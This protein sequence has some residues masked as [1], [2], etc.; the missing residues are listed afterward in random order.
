MSSGTRVYVPRTRS[1][2]YA[3]L[4]GLF[5]KSA[6]SAE[7]AVTKEQL[8]KVAQ[9]YC[10]K[11]F[12]TKWK[13]SRSGEFGPQSAWS[14]MSDLVKKRKLV[15]ESWQSNPRKKIF[16]LS[17][18]GL[19]VASKLYRTSSANHQAPKNVQ[20]TSS[21]T[22]PTS[23]TSIQIV[24]E[25]GVSPSS[26]SS[27]PLRN[28]LSESSPSSGED[29]LENCTLPE[30]RNSHDNETCVSLSASQIAREY[31]LVLIADR[32]EN[33]PGKGPPIS[34]KIRLQGVDCFMTTLSLGDFAWGLKKK[35]SQVSSAP[36]Y[37]VQSIIERKTIQDLYCSV[38][39]G[40]YKEQG[41]RLRKTELQV[42]YILE[43]NGRTGTTMDP[44][45]RDGVENDLWLRG[46][47]VHTTED[48]PSTV[49]Y[50]VALRQGIE[51]LIKSKGVSKAW[52]FE[53]FQRI[54]QHT[55]KTATVGTTWARM[56]LQIPGV[57]ARKAK[58]IANEYPTLSLLVRKY[59][60]LGEDEETK[61]LLLQNLRSD[62]SALR[63]GPRI[64]SL[65]YTA[66]TSETYPDLQI[67]DRN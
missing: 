51:M 48:A 37:V 17:E 24:E 40:R 53:A 25:E 6:E 52:K 22:Q 27:S 4:I 54:F 62:P 55:R 47:H 41:L 32:R 46:T 13:G 29:L 14:F 19:Q 65:V 42:I 49:D 38:M 1:G 56:L 18:E 67:V 26:S 59:D 60:E 7:L 43:G 21:S 31:D 44:K 20:E 36:E 57:G 50:L 8:T 12:E 28:S 3:I 5:E 39:D 58:A 64:S 61:K 23:Q 9:P 30:Q 10:D 15:L 34:E 35:T 2:A 33:M 16:Y 45:V 11:Q 63:V 66:I